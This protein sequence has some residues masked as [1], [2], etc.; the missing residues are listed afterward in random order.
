MARRR[1]L[2]GEVVRAQEQRRREAARLHRQQVAAGRAAEQT[3]LK[4]RRDADRRSTADVRE[5]RRILDAQGT[6]EAERLNQDLE[7]RLTGLRELLT[8]SRP[9]A[10][11][12]SALRQEVRLPPFD[13]GHLR[14]PLAPPAWE[15]FAPPGPP[16]GLAA[17]FGGLA[18]YERQ[19]AIAREAFD[20]AMADYRRAEAERVRQLS[21]HH[22]RYA[23][24]AADIRG[25]ADAHNAAVAALER[26]FEAGEPDAV[27]DY[28]AQLLGEARYPDDFP[29]ERRLAYRPEPRELWIEAELPLTSVVPEER[30]FRYIRTR[31]E[32]DTFARPEREI[33]Q[34]YASLTAQVALRML[35]DCFAGD[36]GDLV[37]TVVFNGHVTTRDP[38]TGKPIHPCLVSVSA[39]RTAFDELELAHLDP[40]ACLRHLNAVVST[41]PYDLVA[42]QPVVD[43]S[44]AQYKFIDELDAAAGLDGRSD[45]LEMDPFRFEHL[46]R[47]LFEKIGLDSWV[48]QGSRDDGVDAVARNKD[49]IL[50]GV[51]VIQAKRYKGVVDAEAVRALWGTMEDKRATTGILVTT[52]WFGSAGRQFAAN[53]QERL[54]LIE[55][56]E[57]KHLLAEYLG[58][59]IRI[60]LQRPPRRWGR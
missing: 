9:P 24:W 56:N 1:S 33:K 47:Q 37:D 23:R 28:F 13:P 31:S 2:W 17:T 4:A 50:G 19:V 60:G 59:D 25:K 7:T 6:A 57:L 45:L 58:L 55:G 43:F 49:P 40:V 36:S 34:L 3:M 44:L 39:N 21:A 48:T 12:L 38:A 22:E 53:H 29:D 8:A 32:I 35:R 51:C 42:V 16:T 46:V 41:N 26:A 14:K 10:L 15:R 18:R 30:G 27:E 5:Q 20:R 11:R 52:S 54:R